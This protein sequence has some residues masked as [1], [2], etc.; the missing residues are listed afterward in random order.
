M[1][2]WKP[3]NPRLM[4]ARF[5]GKC[6]NLSVIVCYA[7]TNEAED[8]KKDEFYMSLQKAKDEVPRLDMLLVLGDLNAQVGTVNI[9]MEDTLGQ[10]GVG[11]ANDNGERLVQFGRINGMVIGGSIFPQ[12]D[13]HM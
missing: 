9:G 13:I 4:T 10:H 7:P 2:D 12:K 8:E 11:T 5:E 3:I 1:I 6:T